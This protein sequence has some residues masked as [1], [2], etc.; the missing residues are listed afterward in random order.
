MPVVATSLGAQG[1]NAKSGEHLLIADETETFAKGVVDLLLNP[2]RA[3][4]IG[5]AGQ[6]LV[7]SL[8]NPEQIGP[9]LEDLLQS[10]AKT[11]RSSVGRLAR[12]LDTRMRWMAATL[13]R[14]AGEKIGMRFGAIEMAFTL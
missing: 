13:P 3:T 11:P 12:R 7:S 6:D 8:T 10:V 14:A 4:E 9:R 2:S 1:F 5:L